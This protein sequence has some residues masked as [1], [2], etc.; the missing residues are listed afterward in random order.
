MG[1]DRGA[2]NATHFPWGR[3][4]GDTERMDDLEAKLTLA[5]D[6]LE[7]L[8][9]TVFRQQEQLDALERRLGQLTRQ[10]AG[11]GVGEAGGHPADEVP[12]HY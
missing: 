3:V 1:W 5:E 9:L 12:P 10:L 4:M 2:Y 11:L 8:N 6:L 7:S